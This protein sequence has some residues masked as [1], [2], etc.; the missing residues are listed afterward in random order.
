ML[1]WSIVFKF[2][3]RTRE[4]ADLAIWGTAANHSPVNVLI[5]PNDGEAAI[6]SW[7]RSSRNK[8]DKGTSCLPTSR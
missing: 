2:G 7:P 6:T 1:C 3:Q 4:L 5:P 8:G